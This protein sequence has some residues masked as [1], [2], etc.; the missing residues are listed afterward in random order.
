MDKITDAAQKIMDGID[1]YVGNFFI[2]ETFKTAFDNFYTNVLAPAG[3]IGGLI[4]DYTYGE[5]TELTYEGEVAWSS[6]SS[7][8]GED[9]IYD[10]LE[11]YIPSDDDTDTPGPVAEWSTVGPWSHKFGTNYGTTD[12]TAMEDSFGMISTAFS[13]LD[14][15]SEDHDWSDRPSLGKKLVGYYYVGV[16]EDHSALEDEGVPAWSDGDIALGYYWYIS[17]AT[18]TTFGGA[19]GK[20]TIYLYK[21]TADLAGSGHTSFTDYVEEQMDIGSETSATYWADG[22]GPDD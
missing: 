9:G 14:A 4:A 13:Y 17:T 12:V 11:E 16:H 18:P 6:C 3:A 15:F 2:L 19:L 7:E 10:V 22:Y 5:S 8:T 1:P 20:A 21:A